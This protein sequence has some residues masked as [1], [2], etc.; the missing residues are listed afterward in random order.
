MKYANMKKD[1]SVVR[2]KF[3]GILAAKNL[4]KCAEIFLFL[5]Y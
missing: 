1:F 5:I 2:K 4:K 3:L